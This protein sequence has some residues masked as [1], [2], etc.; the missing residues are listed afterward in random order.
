MQ[1]NNFTREYAVNQ[2]SLPP[3]L[4]PWS[5]IFL[6]GDRFP[7][8]PAIFSP[9]MPP[10]TYRELAVTIKRDIRVLR[11]RNTGAEDRVAV[12][13][14]NGPLLATT[15]LSVSAITCCAPLSPHLTPEE[16]R[17]EITDL[18]CSAV[19]TTGEG[20][21]PIHDVAEELGI[22]IITA[23]HER[24]ISPG[25]VKI[26]DKGDAENDGQFAPDGHGTCLIMH[27]SGTTARPKIV[28]L[29]REN[30]SYSAARISESLS[31]SPADRCLNVMPLFHVHGLIG[32]LFS[33]LASGSSVIC[34]PGFSS[35][36][37]F[38][39]INEL[40]PTWY[41]AV[42]TIH[43]AVFRQGVNM[44]YQGSHQLRFI[45]SCSSPLS[46][47]LAAKIEK[48]FSTPVIEAYG[49]SEATHQISVNPLPPGI[50]KHGS[51]GLPAGCEVAILSPENRVLSTGKTGEIAI[52]GPNVFSGYERNPKANET[53]FTR[54]WLRTGD[55]GYRD[56]DGYLF[57]T[58][59]IKEI[60]NK[61]GEKVSPREIDEVFFNHPDV[62]AAVAFGFPHQTLGEDIALAVVPAP[63]KRITVTQLRHYALQRL[64]PFKV[65]S[66]F[67]IV[68]EIPKGVT[69]KIS[70][71]SLPALFNLSEGEKHA[72]NVGP[73]A[74]SVTG[75]R[76]SQDAR[77]IGIWQ[78]VLGIAPVGIDD[79]FFMLD[80]TSLAAADMVAQIYKNIGTRLAPT[81][82]YRTPSIRELSDFI[83]RG[84]H[85]TTYLLTLQ[86]RGTRP[87][88]FLVPPSDGSAFFYAPLVEF[89]GL[90]QPVYSFSWPGIDG[91]EPVPDSIVD[92]AARFLRDIRSHQDGQ[93]FILGGFCFGGLVALEMARR[94][95]EENAKTPVLILLD[96]D[97]PMN[98]PGWSIRHSSRL[99][100]LRGEARLYRERGSRFFARVQL[101]RIRRTIEKLQMDRMQVLFRRIQRGHIASSMR[102]IADY[103]PDRVL[104]IM[105]E[106]Y[107]Q[108][109]LVPRLKEIFT[110]PSEVRV[111]TGSRHRELI[112]VGVD[113]ISGIISR[114]V[115]REMLK[116]QGPEHHVEQN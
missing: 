65:P 61:G 62:S 64:A 114:E 67:F 66:K 38:A 30:L 111:I 25:L 19:I 102:Y 84:L 55:L 99:D 85:D 22:D 16:Y 48:L 100:N 23:G 34:S 31:L 96:P 37:F 72:D 73:E 40:N 57:I 98:G 43:E 93:P 13:L 46:P 58:G 24:G 82:L 10:L 63:G 69:G 92:I 95:R 75:P 7:Q 41:S 70:R 51:V 59:R 17:F 74:R 15:I 28:P 94:F 109:S 77:L 5:A 97:F 90:D 29:S 4:S 26:C 113:I 53:S 20:R 87:P 1:G 86:P 2:D 36:N 42:P 103:Y 110:G 52:K 6:N 91:S 3:D 78:D 45:R 18:M 107:S 11:E 27:T 9:G 101:L 88:I 79:D 14:P 83:G 80:G 32:C 116:T 76:N 115:S 81:I 21:N 49:M 106:E 33:S 47:M 8:H 104:V 89:L 56:S 68:S 39:W 112:A 105:S 12:V 44:N 60:I 108:N 71:K 54:G 50:R 35:G